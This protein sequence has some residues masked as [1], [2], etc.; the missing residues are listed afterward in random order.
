MPGKDQAIRVRRVVIR[1]NVDDV[2]AIRATGVD[3][4]SGRR[5]EAHIDRRA[6]G[7]QLFRTIASATP[8][9]GAHV[10]GPPGSSAPTA[11]HATASAGRGVTVA[12]VSATCAGGPADGGPAD[13]GPA[14]RGP[15]GRGPAGR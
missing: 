3:A 8:I 14:G 2:F 13:G 7:R 6:A 11:T 4:E 5:G 10:A 1:R 12:G 15:A 9:A